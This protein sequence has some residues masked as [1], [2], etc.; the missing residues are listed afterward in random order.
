MRLPSAAHLGEAEGVDEPVALHEQELAAE[1]G[2]EQLLP[3][4][5]IPAHM[6]PVS[7]NI[8]WPSE[9][10]PLLPSG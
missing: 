3:A 6:G 5:R 8:F 4:Q 7:S 10:A 2:L 1:Q 9:S